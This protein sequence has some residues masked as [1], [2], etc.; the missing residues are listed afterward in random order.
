[1]KLTD[2]DPAYDSS[3]IGTPRDYTN[4][5]YKVY[6]E[7]SD[8]NSMVESILLNYSSTP[9]QKLDHGYEAV[10][11]IQMV[12]DIIREISIHNIAIYQVV[13]YAKFS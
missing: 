6:F 4:D 12:P 13:R 1:M 10:L 3:E 9:V 7:V 2:A 11:A 5:K 8:V